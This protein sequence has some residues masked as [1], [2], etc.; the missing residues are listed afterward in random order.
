MCDELP[1]AQEQKI[2][3]SDDIAKL[4][5]RLSAMG[6]F[7]AQNNK[8]IAT[9]LEELSFSKPVEIEHSESQDQ[10]FAALCRAKINIK[11]DFEKTGTSNRGSSATLPD[12]V[13]HTGPALYAEGLVIIQEP[14]ERGDYDY[15]KTTITHSSGQW[16]SSTC[17]IRPDYNKG[18]TSAIQAYAS[19]LTSMKRYVY[20][21]ILNLHTGGDKE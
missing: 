15:L 19:A 5:D 7:I 6:K 14:I 3:L 18:G 12:M 20:G 13:Y 16:R 1:V 8:E 11:P 10:L 21:A 4:N 17:A 2:S 9:K